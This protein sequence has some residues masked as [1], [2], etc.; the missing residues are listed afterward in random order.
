MFRKVIAGIEK[1]GGYPHV[2]YR[3]GW[4][5]WPEA[6]VSFV[7]GNV[8]VFSVTRIGIP[9]D[10]YKDTYIDLDNETIRLM[11]GV[12]KSQTTFSSYRASHLIYLDRG[13]RKE[14]NYLWLPYTRPYLEIKEWDMKKSLPGNYKLF[15]ATGFPET[16]RKL[17]FWLLTGESNYGEY[18][19][20][21]DG[22]QPPKWNKV[23]DKMKEI[24]KERG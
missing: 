9:G 8:D 15:S 7:D 6:V 19:E 24:L 20:N 23:Y 13:S 1:I 2:L 21:V 5:H 10:K 22:L 16:Q 12:S 3:K 4:T 11:E 17:M 18:V 14:G